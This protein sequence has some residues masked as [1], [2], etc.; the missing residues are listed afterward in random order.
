M[1]ATPVGA[2]S[3]HVDST[4]TTRQSPS[5]SANTQAS[6]QANIEVRIGVTYAYVELANLLGTQWLERNLKLF[7]THLLNLV[8]NTKSVSSHLDAVHSRKCVQF[9]LRSIVGGML[10]EKMQI[11]AALELVHVIDKCINGVDIVNEERASANQQH[12]LICA[13]YE[14]S[15]IVKCL[16]TST[17]VLVSDD[18]LKMI[19]KVILTLLY[20]NNAVKCVGAWCLRTIACSLPALMCSL[21]DNCLDKLSLIRNPSDALLGY[22]YA[23]AALLGGVNQCHLGIPHLKSKLAFNIGEE[24]LRTA[25]QSNNITLAKQKNSIGWLLLGAFMTL[26]STI[27]RKH[28]PRLKRLWTS[29]MPISLEQIESEKKRGDAFTWQLSLESRAGALASMHSFLTHCGDLLN[30]ERT[31]LSAIVGAVEGALVLLAQLPAI[32]KQNNN[33]VNLK[34]QAAMYRLKLYQTLIALPSADLYESSFALILRELVAEFTLADQHTSNLVTSTLR[35]VCHSNDSILF[36][37]CWLQDDDFKAIEDQLQPYSASGCETL[38]HD[39]T[40][41]YQ[42]AKT[43]PARSSLIMSTSPN[44]HGSGTNCACALPLGVA[45]IDASIQLFGL[46][47][48][49]IP[50]KHRLQMLVHF[51]DSIQKM[52]TNKS[53]A[54]NKQ[55]LQINIFTAVLGSLKALAE[56]KSELGDEAIREATLKLVMETLCHSN[57]ILRCAA[58]EALGRM[59]QVVGESHFVVKVAQFCFEKLRNSQDVTSRTGYALGLGCLHRYLGTMG[60][61]QHMTSSVS[62]LFAMAQ[63]S[64]SSIVQVWA[65]HALYLI[66]DSGGSMF[67]NYVDTCVEFIV[68]SVLSIPHTNR[69]VFVGLGKL[70]NSLITFMGPEI[71]ANAATISS[72]L[73]TC[74]VMQMHTD[75]MI[76]A[77]AIQ[78]LQELH[79]FASKCVNLTELVPYLVNA[80]VSKEFLLRK[81]AIACL[82]QVCQKNALDVCQ[83]A[84]SFVQETKPSGLLALIGER[85]VQCLLFKMLDIESNPQLIRNLHDILNSLLCSTLNESTL[86]RWL[87]LCKDISIGAEQ[88]QSSQHAQEHPHARVQRKERVT[89]DDEEED[90]DSQTLHATQSDVFAV[91]NNTNLSLKQI[92]KNVSPKWPNR[93]FAIELIRRII[94]MCTSLKQNQAHFDLGLAKKLAKRDEDYLILFLQDLMQIACISAVNPCDPLKLAG[95]DLL[96]DLITQFGHVEEPNPEFKGHLILEQ[97]QAQVSAGLRPQFSIETSAH[98]TA[99]ACQVCS[100]WISSGVARDLNDLRRI[101]QLL[102]SSLQKLTSTHS[103]D[104]LIY[105]ELSLTIEKLAVL[106]AW[107]EVY[108]VAQQNKNSGLLS[109]VKPEL[110]MLSYHWSMALKDY[111]FLCLPS[112]YASQL[113]IEGGSFYHA[114]LVD[115]SKPIYK[116][117]FTKILLAYSVWLEQSQFDID[118]MPANQHKLEGE[119]NSS[120]MTTDSTGESEEEREK[121]LSERKEKLF[122]MLLGLALETL[123]NTT[124]LTQLSDETVE[125]ILEAIETLLRTD[126]ARTV[127]THKST[128]L[129]VEILSILYKVKLTRDLM[130]INMSVIRVVLRLNQFRIAQAEREEVVVVGATLDQTPCDEQTRSD[131]EK[132]RRDEKCAMNLLFVIL[133]ICVRDLIK[134]VPNLL[135][136]TAKPTTTNTSSA[137]KSFIHLHV[138]QCKVLS[139][140]DVQLIH[141]V[142]KALCQLVFHSQIPITSKSIPH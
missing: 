64:N 38:E 39:V 51:T 123:S 133:E 13:L 128:S 134:Y 124:G 66:I 104:H 28:V 103:P 32:I 46:M 54:A 11:Q 50:N 140:D 48:P 61:G 63:N 35:S 106:R 81:V 44:Q 102:V 105:S 99:K 86:K 29:A 12:V 122:F 2:T 132:E 41:L 56:S 62:I 141:L 10:N 89:V 16:S 26:G 19:D 93:V 90:D 94:H 33:S 82:R 88:S 101:H 120:T 6:S 22:G 80:L 84:S 135:D 108:I 97:Y 45:V 78:C 7:L 119:S 57:P 24:L 131:S 72:C 37:N 40:Y 138:T 75:P 76:K 20:P 136:S 98:V 49:K 110:D 114:D 83:I 111:A 73:I 95:L 31:L 43:S 59:A 1:P 85:G 55:A 14:L 118:E 126:L 142:L 60:A 58:G 23:C 65:I 42:S 117:H 129:C 52:P 18:S 92:T 67:R 125:N 127:L 112:E 3:P 113:P 77:E 107:A 96:Y 116:E 70:L 17:S 27:V 47:Y 137:T 91:S 25:S 4:T 109:L 5:S 71:E 8:N 30:E 9:V 79:L 15:C 69:D 139:R 130:S 68:Q 100:I 34:V 53:N 21:L 115:S 36:V 87:F 74:T 121:R